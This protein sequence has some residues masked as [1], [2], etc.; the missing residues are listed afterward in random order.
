MQTTSSLTASST[1]ASSITAMSTE[2]IL[3]SMAAY[4][5]LPESQALVSPPTQRAPA[6]VAEMHT[7]AGMQIWSIASHQ[8]KLESGAHTSWF[9][10]VSLQ[11]A[12][13]T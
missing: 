5:R 6:F 11:S 13:K 3:V 7:P 2:S 4:E 12:L 1:T 9:D 10:T 8:I